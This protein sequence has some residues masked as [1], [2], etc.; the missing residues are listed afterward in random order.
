MEKTYEFP[1]EDLVLVQ[2]DQD[3]QQQDDS[4]GGSGEPG[5]QQ[6]TDQ[7]M[8]DEITD[9]EVDRIQD[10]IEDALS[11]RGDNNEE[12]LEK[13][14]QRQGQ[15]SGS[16][17]DQ[18]GKRSPLTK[19]KEVA[20]KFTWRELMQQFI[21]TQSSADTTYQKISRRGISGIAAAAQSGAG[22][23]VPGE[24]I[25]E[26]GFRLLFVFDT[27]G[28]MYHAVNTALGE[29]QNLIKN[30]FDRVEGK[31][32]VTFFADSPMHF[33]AD[34]TG[35][36]SWPVKDFTEMDRQPATVNPLSAVF[37]IR[38]SGGTNFG[39]RMVSEISRVIG[40]GYNAIIFTD[41]DIAY[42]DNWKNFLRLYTGHRSN[43]FLIV[44]NRSSFDMIV[45]KLG[46]VPSTFGVLE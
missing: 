46:T 24:K 25:E 42:G 40:L 11:G 2:P 21:M 18:S 37:K 29:A 43:I 32:G 26:E 12:D 13:E 39:P 34:L 6:E 41:S 10:E 16:Q 19:A 35:D 20:P 38:G 1:I 27:S 23:I 30:N 5:D 7:E 9:D 33:V 4:D 17:A 31:V 44:D 22:A 45:K 8:D 14:Q 28:S 36:R 3:D 15:S